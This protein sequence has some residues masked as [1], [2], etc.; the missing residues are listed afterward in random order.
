MSSAMLKIKK[1]SLFSEFFEAFFP[2]SYKGLQITQKLSCIKH[3][4]L[5]LAAVY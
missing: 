4:N 5:L 1:Y 2:G 3:V